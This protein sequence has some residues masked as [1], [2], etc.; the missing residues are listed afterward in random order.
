MK[1]V[2][3]FEEH[4]MEA[5][6]PIG[7]LTKKD[8]DWVKSLGDNKVMYND[9]QGS[10]D[11]MLSGILALM[12]GQPLEPNDP[13]GSAK[14]FGFDHVDMYNVKTGRTILDDATGGEYTFDQL[15]QKVKTIK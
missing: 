5:R 13:S 8:E 7:K 1:R 14:L 9:Q 2:K 4:L 11:H 12:A 3:S 10:G 15:L 6:K